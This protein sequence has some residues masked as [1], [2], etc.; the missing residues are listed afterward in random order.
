MPTYVADDDNKDTNYEIVL[1]GGGG[2]AGEDCHV[3]LWF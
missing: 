2:G 3:S 1:R